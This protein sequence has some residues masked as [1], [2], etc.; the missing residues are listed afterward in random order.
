MQAATQAETIIPARFN[1]PPGS[2]NGGYTCGAL[3]A[4]VE[5]PATVR[6]FVPPPLDKPLSVSRA[7]DG[8]VTAHD[9]ETLVGRA[10]PASLELELP[11]APS[12]ADAEA[13][14]DNFPCYHD[15]AFPTCF[16]C[17]PGREAHDGLE[18]FPGSAGPG[19]LLACRWQAAADLLDDAGNIRHEILWSALDCPGYFAA[20]E[21]QLRPALLGELTAEI[22]RE[23]SG[24][25]PLV[26]YAWP[27]G[28]EGRK[29][30][31]GTAIAT[32]EGEVVAASHSTWI[33]LK[34]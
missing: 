29:F 5:G 19:K 28:S 10:T 32:A 23:V 34:G 22:Y 16:V 4:F 17:G 24:E 33:E 3:A 6:L 14:M 25:Q 27:L 8:I 11:P 13:A 2:G 1:G 7:E 26:V 20:M 30:Y 21:G 15:H 12:M 18:I 31:G 9:G